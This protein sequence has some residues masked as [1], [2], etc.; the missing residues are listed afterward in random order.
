MTH[1]AEEAEGRRFRV[2]VEVST[3]WRT[4]EAPREMDAAAVADAPDIAA[5]LEALD[6]HGSSARLDLHDRTLTQFVADEPVM[7]VAEADGWAHVIGVWQPSPLDPRGYPAWVPRAHLTPADTTS[8]DGPPA[9][10]GVPADAQA[11]CKSARQHLGLQYLWG[12]TTPYGLDCSGLVHHSYRAAGIVVPRDAHAQYEAA[13]PVPLGDER[14]GDLYFFARE[15]GYVFHVG[16]VSGDQTMLH[17]PETGR[18]IE[19][20][21]MNEQRR[22]TL[23]AA[24]R[25]LD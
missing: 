13:K 24:G 25:F 15:N 10:V 16:F 8:W 21:P 4:P 14:P 17:A 18:G 3:G 19:E 20:G 23:F 12:G 11:V 5:W 7:L 9:G 6:A 22:R 2:S 1:Q